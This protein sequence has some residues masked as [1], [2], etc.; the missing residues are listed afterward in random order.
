MNFSQSGSWEVLQDKAQGDLVPD[1]DLLSAAFLLCPHLV[2]E[3][4]SYLQSF[5]KDPNVVYELDP[6][7]PIT[8]QRSHLREPSIRN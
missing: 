2:K 8:S 4:R 1:E 6:H 7:D 3:E 5:C